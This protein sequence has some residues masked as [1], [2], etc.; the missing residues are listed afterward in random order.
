M[1]KIT[2]PAGNRVDIDLSGSIDADTMRA[3]LDELVDASEGVVNGRMRYTIT[4]FG[5]P[6]L[7]AIGIE[8]TRLPKLFGLIG[9]FD[10]CAVLC[11][12]EWIRKA[13]ALEGALIPELEIKSFTLEDGDGAEAW[14]AEGLT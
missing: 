4:E 10:K 1:F 8:I 14:L 5:L 12:A 3:A 6:T 2:K 9:K 11:D 7:G 13:A